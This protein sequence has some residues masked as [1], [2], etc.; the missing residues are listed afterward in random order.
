VYGK[1][2]ANAA[3]VVVRHHLVDDVGG[4][5]GG[6]VEAALEEI[7]YFLPCLSALVEAC[8]ISDPASRKAPAPFASFA[9]V[10][11]PT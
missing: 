1:D 3:V 9:I 2:V 10:F 4:T 11:S 6:A 5:G 7:V 8:A